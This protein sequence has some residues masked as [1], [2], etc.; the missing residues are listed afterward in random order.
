MPEDNRETAQAATATADCGD[1]A[2]TIK[3]Q[4]EA[5]KLCMFMAP[6]SAADTF[7]RTARYARDPKQYLLDSLGPDVFEARKDLLLLPEIVDKDAYGTGVHKANFERGLAGLFGK[8]AGLFFLT[9]VQA[10]LAAVKTHCERSGNSRVAWHVSCHL[11]SA[12]ERAYETLYQ[13]ER[14]LLG[15]DENEL[16]TVNEIKEVLELPS[17]KRPAVIV[18]EIPNRVLGCQTYSYDELCQISSLC[19]DAGVKLH[20]DGARIWEIEPYYQVTFGKSFKDLASLF[21][22]IYVSFYKGVGGLC[23]AMLMAD[24]ESLIADAKM[25]QRRAGGNAFTLA[26]EVIDSERGFNENIGTFAFKRQ[27]MLEV[28]DAIRSATAEY[29]NAS[30]QPIVQFFPDQPFCCQVR[31]FFDGFTQEDLCAARDRAQEKTGIRVFERIWPKFSLDEKMAA[32]RAGVS[33]EDFS[34]RFPDTKRHVIE[35]MIMNV[36]QHIETKT[37][38]EGYVAMCKELLA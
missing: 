33:D 35:W 3:P 11:E 27:K 16:P 1:P 15:S 30:G 2:T 31:T 29:K 38:V 23:G 20:C 8:K 32:N 14:T 24:D 13:L 10:Q 28:A 17:D 36:T 6:M 5:T 12:E 19:Q 34:K 25:W 4:P 18:L 22:T 9:G 21:D 7:N 37:F 26:G